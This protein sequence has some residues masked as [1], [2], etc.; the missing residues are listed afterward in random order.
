MQILRFLFPP[1]RQVK[2]DTAINHN[3]YLVK[4]AATA[5]PGHEGTQPDPGLCQLCRVFA[6]VTEQPKPAMDSN[7][8][9]KHRWASPRPE[10]R[11]SPGTGHHGHAGHHD[12]PCSGTSL[13]GSRMS[14]VPHGG[15]GADPQTWGQSPTLLSLHL[16][17]SPC[18]G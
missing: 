14:P 13:W 4:D 9:R 15:D 10:G 11:S 16:C 3:E 2:W 5:P 8:I 1:L 6:F 17:A 7:M 18:P 12:S